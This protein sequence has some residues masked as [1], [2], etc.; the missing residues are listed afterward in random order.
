M[1]Y[2]HETAVDFLADCHAFLALHEA[3]NNLILG[4]AG[5]LSRDPHYYGPQDPLFLTVHHPSGCVAAILQTPPRN[6]ILYVDSAHISY[7]IP[8][9]IQHLW[10]N[11]IPVP[12]V[13]GPKAAIELF[14]EEW[15]QL[16]SQTA[17]IQFHE[18]VYKLENVQAV[19]TVPGK[20]RQAESRDLDFLT[21]WIGAFAAQ[22]LDEM[23]EEEARKNAE[24]KIREGVLYL[25]E[26]EVPVT[27]AGW[28]RPTQHGVTIAYVYTPTEFRRR[29]Y[30]TACVAA[31]S[32]KLLADYD[33]C[34]LFTDLNNPTSNSIYQKIGYK[35]LEY[36]LQYGFA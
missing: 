18:M 10:T 11:Q 6:L 15:T 8:L 23:S 32:Q 12:G 16:T 33:F 3:E 31:L 30:A 7:A 5:T 35:P 27:M 25:W 28:T 14:V 19:P 20:M 13:H 4:L 1:I 29:G 26:D 21:D 9:L 17:K 36:F 34:A 2:T 24:R 22:A